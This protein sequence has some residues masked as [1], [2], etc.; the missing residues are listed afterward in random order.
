MQDLDDLDLLDGMCFVRQLTDPDEIDEW[1]SQDDHFY[2]NQRV[3]DRTKKLNDLDAG[4]LRQCV[5]CST[6]R[7]RKQEEQQKLLIRNG[8]IRCLELFS[9]A[10]KKTTLFFFIRLSCLTPF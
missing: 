2:V 7:R 6:E 8:P 4:L 9:G 10:V 3:D 1:V 5:A